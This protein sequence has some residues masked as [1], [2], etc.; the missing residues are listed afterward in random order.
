MEETE[1]MKYIAAEGTSDVGELSCC[2]S[3]SPGFIYSALLWWC[4]SIIWSKFVEGHK[5]CFEMVFFSMRALKNSFF[6]VV[7]Y[8]ES[9]HSYTAVMSVL[10]IQNYRTTIAQMFVFFICSCSTTLKKCVSSIN[11]SGGNGETEYFFFHSNL[12]WE[13]DKLWIKWAPPL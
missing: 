1:F 13:K 10:W 6:S 7:N 9:S 11:E 8:C 2:P 5:H 12:L 3:H 4:D